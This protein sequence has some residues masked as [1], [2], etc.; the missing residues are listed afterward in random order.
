MIQGT[1]IQGGQFILCF[2]D[3]LSGPLSQ[4]HLLQ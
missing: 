4:T 3:I 1:Y 2:L